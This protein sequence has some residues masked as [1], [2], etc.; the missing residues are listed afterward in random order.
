M[1]SVNAF[2]ASS[3]LVGTTFSIAATPSCPALVA[4][5]LVVAAS[6]AF[7]AF[8]AAAAT[9]LFRSR[10]SPSLR[11]SA[12]VIN[13]FCLTT[14]A[15]TAALA[16]FFASQ[17]GIIFSAINGSPFAFSALCSPYKREYMLK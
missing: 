14:A 7:L 10:F 2:L 4:P 11:L 15:S 17:L 9:W 12:L 13:A 1:A 6:I 16:A 3:R 5:S 8:V